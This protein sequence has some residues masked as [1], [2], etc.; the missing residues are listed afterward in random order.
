[1]RVHELRREMAL[2][3]SRGE[4][5]AF[6]SDPANL[7]AITPPW[8][9]FRTVT[10]SPIEMRSGVLIDYKMNIHGFPIRWQSRITVWEPPVRFVDEQVRGPYRLWIHEHSFRESHGVT[11]VTDYVRY[12]LPIDWIVRR[13][14]VEPDLERIFAYRAN[15]LRDRLT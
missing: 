4:V 1:M 2:P 7:D 11:V 5:F 14:L 12:A 8:L 13:F 6:F 10:E 15:K 3:R 9:R